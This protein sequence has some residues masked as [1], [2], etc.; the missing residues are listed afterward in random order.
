MCVQFFIA[1]GATAPEDDLQA[2]ALFAVSAGTALTE[3]LV[4]GGV[5][6]E[7]DAAQAMSAYMKRPYTC[8]SYA[9]SRAFAAFAV[10]ELVWLV[11]TSSVFVRLSVLTAPVVRCGVKFLASR[12]DIE[13]HVCDSAAPPNADD[14]VADPMQG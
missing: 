5:R 13:Q 4:W 14:D 7:P 1:P 3:W 11:C 12:I 2:G 9:R 10:P 8:P 6:A